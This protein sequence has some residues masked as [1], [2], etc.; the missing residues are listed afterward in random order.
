M[1]NL[2]DRV[3]TLESVLS[4]YIERGEKEMSASREEMNAFREEMRASREESKEE[5]RASREE[6]KEEIRAFKEEMKIFKDETRAFKEEIRADR[7]EMNRQWGNLSN[8]MGTIVEDIVAPAVRPAVRKYFQVDPY[9]LIRS[10]RKRMDGEEYE[11]DALAISDRQVFWVEAK[12]SP[13]SEHVEEV[14]KKAG[15]FGKFF[16]EYQ[17]KQLVVILAGLSFPPD[18]IQHASRKGVY[19]LAYREWDYMD[20]L[21]FDDVHP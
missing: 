7:R 19:V 6:S 3:D 18:V 5:M 9:L 20:I 4:R 17:D 15:H 21:N 14:L 13:R 10:M 11:V 12:S 1:A 8:K 16:P 2:E